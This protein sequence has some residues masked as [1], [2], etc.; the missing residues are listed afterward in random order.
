MLRDTQMFAQ[1][2]P[3][4]KWTRQSTARDTILWTKEKKKKEITKSAQNPEKHGGS[5]M[6]NMDLKSTHSTALI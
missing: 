4:V 5:L 6:E 3:S 1:E 2:A